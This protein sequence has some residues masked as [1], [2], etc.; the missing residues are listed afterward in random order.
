[1]IPI[2]LVSQSHLLTTE[3]ANDSK[4]QLSLPVRKQMMSLYSLLSPATHLFDPYCLWTFAF[5]ILALLSPFWKLSLVHTQCYVLWFA[6]HPW[7][8]LFFNFSWNILLTERIN[9]LL[10]EE[11]D[12]E[13]KQNRWRGSRGANFQL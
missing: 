1:M 12:L 6:N 9:W 2:V 10:P 11:K 13:S 5:K 4:V 3:S 7:I 8:K